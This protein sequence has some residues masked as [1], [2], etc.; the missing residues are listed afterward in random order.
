MNADWIKLT[1]LSQASGTQGLRAK[2]KVWN[3]DDRVSVN[4]ETK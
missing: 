2:T 3:M 1:S 4:I